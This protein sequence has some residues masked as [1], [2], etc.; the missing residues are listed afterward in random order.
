MELIRQEEGTARRR[1][2]GFPGSPERTGRGRRALWLVAAAATL[3]VVTSAATV[4]LMR[5]RL[6]DHVGVHLV[7]EAPGARSV[8]VVGD[9]NGWE[10]DSQHLVDSDGDGVWEI[11]FSVE[12]D[13]EYQYQF[14]VDDERWVHD[15]RS[16][17]LVDD[18]FGGVN[19]ILDI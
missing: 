3:V 16:S 13:R 5:P 4:A 8:A 14:V 2:L 9:W 7:L 17:L 12:R 15:P 19:S 11:R 1:I 18:G 10:T 6:L